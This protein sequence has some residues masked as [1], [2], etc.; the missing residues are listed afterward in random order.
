MKQLKKGKNKDSCKA[1]KG[2]LKSRWNVLTK[3]I[4]FKKFDKGERA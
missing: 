3:N 2:T 4:K 1:G